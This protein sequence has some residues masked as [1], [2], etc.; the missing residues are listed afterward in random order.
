VKRRSWPSCGDTWD[1]QDGGV[2][3]YDDACALDERYGVFA[4]PQ[5]Q[6]A[7]A[8]DGSRD[9]P[10]RSLQDAV[11]AAV[12]ARKNVYACAGVFE[13][14]LRI[15]TKISNGLAMYGGLSCSTFQADAS[16]GRTVVRAKGRGAALRIADTRDVVIERIDFENVAGEHERGTGYLAAFVENARAVVLRDVNLRAD[17]GE[18]GRDGAPPPDAPATSG[19]AGHDGAKACEA[20]PNPGGGA[21]TTPGCSV[22]AAGNLGGDGAVG[23][24]NGGP[25]YF[26][27]APQVA[28]ETPGSGWSCI[29]GSGVGYGPAVSSPGQA[30]RGA[31]GFGAILGGE[32]V[33]LAGQAGAAGNPGF[34]GAGGGG[35]L[36]PASCAGLTVPTG[37]SGG[38][39]GGAGCG[40]L[41]GEHGDG[42]GSS[43]GLLVVDADLTFE[44]G[45]IH[46]GD[47]GR[48]GHGAFG[49][50]GGK[51]APA[52]RGGKGAGGS[53]AACDGTPG[54]DGGEGGPGGGAN[55]G[56][57]I[58]VL[59]LGAAPL[60]IGVAGEAEAAMHQGGEAGHGPAATDPTV[61]AALAG[62][63]GVSAFIFSF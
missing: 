12:N 4:D 40:G 33:S 9:F 28:G 24:G 5:G 17:S 54:A 41:G 30:G 56:H 27:G 60:L 62:T 47:G 21:V 38:G 36:A 14:S 44:S 45:S 49:Q 53:S 52:G 6:T 63:P 57:A 31:R 59:H 46:Y 39:G 18:P 32:F 10:Y 50:A 37:A 22:Q 51:G 58:G 23:S 3:P 8:A 48:G 42:G 26:Y 19:V 16:A 15:G 2:S 35:A 25:G 61:A 29:P 11:V 13:E 34:G 1:D 20:N 43:V 55:G 7:V